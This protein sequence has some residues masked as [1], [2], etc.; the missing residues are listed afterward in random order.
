M[1]LGATTPA[2]HFSPAGDSPYGLHDM[3]GNVWEWTAAW[4]DGQTGAG[5]T[6]L[7]RGGAWPSSADNLRLTYRLDIDPLLRFNTLGFRAVARLGDPGF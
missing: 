3:A 7:I 2:G 6:R 1:A 4:R 5:R